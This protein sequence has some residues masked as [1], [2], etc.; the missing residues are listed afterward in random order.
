MLLLLLVYI[1]DNYCIRKTILYVRMVHNKKNN[2]L[3]MILPFRQL[4]YCFLL[5]LLCVI[6]YWDLLLMLLLLQNDYYSGCYSCCVF[7][8]NFCMFVCIKTKKLPLVLRGKKSCF[9]WYL[10][11]IEFF[12]NI[13]FFFFVL[14]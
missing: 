12:L 11:E 9:L 7:L 6:L 8:F 10:K 5:L 4:Y 3:S 14:F 1:V 13:S 2:C